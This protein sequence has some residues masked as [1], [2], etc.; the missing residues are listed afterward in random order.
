MIPT[1]AAS[2]LSVL[3]AAPSKVPF[4]I[5]G[6]VLAA[7][8]V[9]A[10]HHRDPPPGLPDSK[11]GRRGVIGASLLLVLGGDVDGGGDRRGGARGRGEAAATSSELTLTADP[12]GV[13]RVRPQGGGTV[14]SGHGHGQARQRVAARPQRRGRAGRA[15]AGPLRHDHRGRDRAEGRPAPGRVRVLLHGH[16]PPRGRDGGHA[17][18]AMI[19]PWRRRG[20]CARRSAPASGPARRP[21]LAPGY[22][23]ANLVVLPEADAFDFL[24]FCLRNPKPCPVLE[25]CEPGSP[26]P[27]RLAPGADLRTDLPRYRVW[28]DGELAEERADI[29]ELWREDLVAFLIGCSFT[30]ERALLAAGLPVRHIEQGVNVPM[31]R[32][33]RRVPAG[34]ALL[35]PARR[36]D[37]ADDAAAG[38][39]RR[40]DH[41]PLPGGPRRA[42]CTSATRRRSGIADLARARLRRRGRGPR[43][44]GPGLLGLRRDARRRSRRRQ[45]PRAD[46]H[47]RARATCS[48]LRPDERDRADR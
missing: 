4:Y 19:R 10:R 5:A 44:R 20:R 41:R 36:L 31:Y 17:D 13:G 48:S 11:G 3:A 35:R 40:R 28:R 32:T 25:V 7:W 14:K 38:A 46:D 24:R 16:R 23:Q 42:R 33:S 22:V 26:E 29:R 30:F 47:P 6:G 39:A 15:R 8:A 18:R 43:R 2:A 9:V 21:A 27:R 34:R 37:A 1:G 12:S 45:P